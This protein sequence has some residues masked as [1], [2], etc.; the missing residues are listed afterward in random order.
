MLSELPPRLLHSIK[1]SRE[2]LGDVSERTFYRW[3]SRGEIETVQIARRRLIP[4]D[5]LL[6][7]I[8]RL[9]A[10]AGHNAGPEVRE[11]AAG[12]TTSPT[13]L[14]VAGGSATAP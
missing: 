2:L 1:E 6:A 9:R 8:T 10:K 3:M 11:S 5:S 14:E 7:A 13:A 4:H 12:D